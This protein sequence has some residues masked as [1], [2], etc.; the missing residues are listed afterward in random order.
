MLRSLAR[1]IGLVAF[2]SFVSSSPIARGQSAGDIA[3]IGWIDNGSPDTFAFVAL[4]PI[5]AGTEIYFTDNGWTGTAFRGVTG[6]DANGNEDLCRW[7]ATVAVAEGAI[8]RAY[9]AD[10]GGTWTTSG[11]IGSSSQSYAPLALSTAGDQIYA[12][13]TSD[14]SNPALSP[15]VHLFVLDDTNGFETATS[16]NTGDVPPGVSVAG[17]TALSFNQAGSG[18]NFMAFDTASVASGS[19][20]SVWLAGIA[21]AANWTF[22]SSGTLPSGTV[23]VCTPPAITSH[24]SDVLA[25]PGSPAVFSATATGSA[26]LLYQWRLNTS[27]LSDGG[28]VSGSATDTLT[29]AAAGAGD[30]G[31]YDVVVSNACGN[32][33]SQ[34]A[35]LTLDTLQSFYPDLDGDGYGDENAA[36]VVTC[37]APPNHVLDN[38]DCD[39]ADPAVNPA[40]VEICGNLVDDDCNGLVDDGF[41]T[42]TTVYVDDD[43]ASLSGG[44]DPPGPGT[45]I[46]CDAFATIQA[47]IDAVAAGGTVE[48]AAGTYVENVVVDKTVALTGA[49]QG[50]SIVQPATSVPVCVGGSLCA[51]SSNLMLVQADDVVI[52][53]FTID[54]ANPAISSGN[55]AGG[56]DVDA[57]NGIITNHTLGVY[58][59]LE[60]H[61]VTARNIWLRGIYASSGGT[62]HFHDNVVE[63]VQGEA[64]S[65]GIFNFGG[66]GLVEDNVVDDCNDAIASNWS[67]GT[68]YLDNVVTDSGSA[69]HTDN[70]GGFGGTSD[71][72]QGNSATN[73]SY[74]FWVFAPF[75]APTVSRNVATGCDVGLACAGRNGGAPVEP[76][77]EE[78]TVDGASGAGSVGVYVTTDRF[79]FGSTDVDAE[80]TGN[81]VFD[82][83]YGFYLESQF[84]YV[85]S[86]TASG[87]SIHD[88]TLAG[89]LDGALGTNVVDAS[90]NWWGAASGPSGT[91]LF[92]PLSGSGDSVD[93]LVDFTPWL[94]SGTDLGGVASDG[95][96]GD[97]STLHVD[98]DS[99]QTGSVDRIQ[100]GV[101]LVTASTVKVEPGTYAEFV[102]ANKPVELLGPHADD[103]PG[104]SLD[105]GGEAVVMPGASADLGNLDRPLIYVT[106]DDV[107]IRGLTL[108]GD[109]P[110][111]SGQSVGSATAEV[112]NLVANG[113]FDDDTTYPFVDVERLVVENNI[114]TTANDIAI[115]V[116]NSGTGGV[117][118]ED[119]RFECNRLDNLA[120]L[121]TQ[122]PGGPYNRIA[123]LIYN[124][125]YAVIDANYMTRINIGVQ[126]GNNYQAN[127]GIAASIS[128]NTID[129]DNLAI[130]HNL[131]YANASS[132][133]IDAN[134]IT[135]ST[136]GATTAWGIYVTSIMGAVSA[137]VTDN[138]VD[139]GEVGIA[140]WNNPT[141]ST[142]A[143]LGGTIQDCTLAG[144]QLRNTDDTYGAAAATTME[145]DGVAISDCTSGIRIAAD[146]GGTDVAHLDV[147]N[148]SISGGTAG[149]L[150][151]GGA[152]AELYLSSSL[153]TITGASYGVDVDGG[154]A[155]IETTNLAG[156]SA[157]GIRVRNGGVCDA[158]DKTGSDITGL[159]ASA[160]GNVLT[161]YGFDDA[162][163]W[164]IEDLN[165]SAQSNVYAMLDDYGAT[166]GDDI[167]DVV[168]D[169]TDN[170]ANSTVVASQSG[171]LLVACPADLD[172]S[173]TADVP[174]G[175]TTQAAFQAQGGT[176]SASPVTVSFSDVVTGSVPCN[177][178]IA[179]TY[180]VT[181]AGA[182]Q[183]QCTQQI[184]VVDVTAPSLTVPLDVT[185]SCE[186]STLPSNT[187]Q[188]SANDACQGAVVPTYT[189]TIVSG[190]CS[191]T[192]TIQRTW[193]ASDSCGNTATGV[194]SIGVQD[195]TNPSFTG[196]PTDITVTGTPC[197]AVV[198]WTPPTAQ[199]N[200]GSPGVVASHSPGDTFLAGSTTTVT[201]TATDACGNTAVCSF[202]VTVN[203]GTPVPVTWVDDD[204]SSVPVGTDPDGVGGATAM[205]CDAFAS[206]QDAVD[207]VAIG[208]TVYVLPGAYEEQ[209]VVQNDGVQIVGSG[210]GSNPSFD[211]IL[212]S[213]VSLTY[214]FTSSAN[215]YPVL[216]FA[217]S[218]G[219]SVSDLRIDGLGR[220]NGNYR[221]VGL[222]VY[223]A[224]GS[225]ENV[226]VTG[227]RDTPI[228]G[229][230][231]GVGILAYNNTGGPYSLAIDDCDL[232][233]YQKN[234]MVLAGTGL[235]VAVSDCTVTGAGAVSFI[236]QNGI[237]VGSGAGGTISNC[238]VSGHVYTPATF[239]AVGILPILTDA[240]VDV[241]DCTLANN[242]PGIYYYDA[243]GDVLRTTV[244]ATAASA[245]DGVYLVVD[246]ADPLAPGQQPYRAPSGLDMVAPIGP[247]APD[248]AAITLT[249]CVI[250]GHGAASSAGVY[251]Y[252]A[253]ASAAADLE[254]CDVGAWDY[255]VYSQEDVGGT[256]AVT[257][258]DNDLS[259]N[260]TAATTLAGT[261][262]IDAS[263]NWWG[264]SSAAAVS[265]AA[266]SGVD[267]TPWLDTGT[268]TSANFAFQGAFSTLHADDDS[269]QVGAT[270]RIQ[271]GHDLLT[272]GGTL[273][274]L[275][276]SYTENVA[277]SKRLTLDGDGSGGSAPAGNPST[278][279]IV[280]AANAGAPVLAI[281]ASGTSPTQRLTIQE[282][283]VTGGSDGIGVTAASADYLRFDQV[284]AMSNQ[285]GVHFGAS[286]GSASDVEADDCVLSSNA[287]A[288]LR[289]ASAMSSISG[290]HVTGG[291]MKSNTYFGFSFN[292]TGSASCA[293]TDIDFDGTSFADNGSPSLVGSGHLS[294]FG[295]NGDAE[296]TNLTLTGNT[297]VPIQLRGIGTDGVPGT[298]SP[299]GTVAFDGVTISGNTN[300]PGIYVQLYSSLAGL[301]FDDVDLSGVVSSNAPFTGFAI[302]MQLDHTGTPV[303]LGNTV[304]P[305]QGGQGAGYVGLAVVNT[306]GATADCT[307]VFVGATTHPE[308]ENCIFDVGDFAGI[309][310]VVIDVGAP[311][312]YADVDGDLFGDP[313][314]SVQSCT[315]PPGY[316][317]D[318]TDLCPLDAGKQSPGLCGCGTPDTDSDGDGTPDCNDLCP[319]DPAKVAPGQCG[320]GTPDTDSDGDG[321][322][323]CFDNCPF[324]PNKV[325]PGICG[326]GVSDIDTDGDGTADC[327]D[328]C[329]LD[330]NKV[331]AGQCG[332]GNP[333]TDTDGDGTA[334]CVDLCPF[335]PA[336]VAPGVCGCGVPDVDTDGDGWLDCIDNC[337]TI[338]NPTQ[339]DFDGDGFGDHCDNCP[340]DPNP[341]QEDC[342]NDG[343]GDLCA[344]SLGVSFDCNSNG[345][346]DDCEVAVLDCNSNGV[347]DDCDIAGGTSTDFN[348]NL[349]PDECEGTGTPV[350]FGDGS[351]ST[352]CPC[353]NPGGPGEGCMNT[354][355]TGAKLFNIGGNSISLDDTFLVSNGVRPNAN[356]V[357][358]TGLTLVN[359]GN[360]VGFGA[361]ILC[362]NPL[363]RFPIQ[364]ASPTGVMTLP[365]PVSESLYLISA[366]P[367]W[368]FQTWYRDPEGACTPTRTF[369]T[370][371][372]LMIVFVP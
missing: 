227:I 148:A 202:D 163:P 306:G 211:S 5:A 81:H 108:T 184:A 39:D 101:D 259:A 263:G 363:K 315:Q 157:A 335:D 297:R 302:G 283:R 47:G 55:V 48:V 174:A 71:L 330:P 133:A 102:D 60:V 364:M 1:A 299:L 116:Y 65:I 69:V 275:A 298:W 353:G 305:C 143:I 289:V 223:N 317:A 233:D 225:V 54:G 286:G 235:T 19:V 151:T 356:G 43:F 220:G 334:D 122:S 231:H 228:S 166:A 352:P 196:C 288:G 230:Q 144:V 139:G 201:Y 22:G 195:V 142:I 278:D 37:T 333:D 296:L 271:E 125:T 9:T 127:T 24:P 68:Q 303:P 106:S 258:F 61:H 74:G 287:N 99:L 121:N 355:G 257:A 264:S 113:A 249:Q 208:G 343:L 57:R 141:T 345:I 276:G 239:A 359:G 126:T 273:H 30:V 262:P 325:N 316:V 272:A 173:C 291:E 193:S 66:S 95:F 369:N 11:L 42:P 96:Q 339:P 120:G 110:S 156:N 44:D 167:E 53:G 190:P 175:A 236:A 87:N 3:L 371:S 91:G 341:G 153:A 35:S 368:Y 280:T 185:I 213:P 336:K 17:N 128:G 146:V 82:N 94:D 105:R 319:F 269:P 347:P 242:A 46:G 284:T 189:D 169:D 322:P 62:F 351:G 205:G 159:G 282:V 97:F 260:L 250:T 130:W 149:V 234:G 256:N 92:G 131:H 161:G 246:G 251:V 310:D 165:S 109:N 204:W 243:P 88:N 308:K 212:R 16:S 361:G 77:F 370:S 349:V 277:I 177:Y 265:A 226:D 357:F 344:I 279:T 274:V 314:V 59:G 214:F 366:G 67:T 147:T 350:C 290:L 160:G 327:L 224:G 197:S 38:T 162:A 324:D 76:L 304:F 15:S 312:W 221:M 346:P 123:V 10:A 80:F 367:P 155:R 178:S 318:N 313:F 238:V 179:R 23:G 171:G 79:G 199:D 186:D 40:A 261:T 172:L 337:P 187:G 45:A 73:C 183:A 222:G 348:A 111:L 360:G 70:N 89:M 129:V 237:Q 293:G 229:T 338:P 200:C 51:G 295:F 170:A 307:T 192:Y 203:A 219:W 311:F 140:A 98:D 206:V 254:Q 100:E 104:S 240:D 145:V 241:V 329:P 194:Q 119:N 294:Y 181:D 115:N 247:E 135:A 7:T 292:P 215:N 33:T 154:I 150:V 267:Y 83:D 321:T 216:A 152:D 218:T 28:N 326:C 118:S 323:D 124:D 84:G 332:C 136:A 354:N 12:F 285:N 301:S 300:R 25:C 56:V 112:D 244:D 176:S 50:L 13:T 86:V 117:V 26:T 49:G 217:S 18:Q 252:S 266:T 270:T 182:N 36:P 20:K 207:A 342:D 75:V 58:E 90:G 372:A 78:N 52:S 188:A 340:H 93:A 63:N 4:A 31:S 2:V 158:G 320:C 168:Y 64:A 132:F 209:V 268:D 191:G 14:P 29:I 245:I 180:T 34:T 365:Q 281:G 362:V 41:P 103:C 114:L 137:T 134:V 107:T 198:S 309:G 32:Q 331:S 358:F 164:A 6:T 255:G 85:L 72:I 8:V 210:S 27:P 328:G 253:A 232:D 138:D 248:A 21:N